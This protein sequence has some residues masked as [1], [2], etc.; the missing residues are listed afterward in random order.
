MAIEVEMF[1]PQFQALLQSQ[2]CAVQQSHD[3][4]NGAVQLS[5][6]QGDFCRAEDHRNTMGHLAAGHW[7]DRP[8]INPQ[9]VLVKE[10]ESAESLVLRGGADLLA[11]RQPGQEGRDFGGSEGARMPLL[12][13]D[14]ESAI[15]SHQL[16]WCTVRSVPGGARVSGSAGRQP[17][18]RGPQGKPA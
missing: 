6:D 14:D 4:C 11:G 3:E 16:A 8:D 13:K 12:V 18:R 17:G 7:L 9:D 15:H 10:E 2:S 5:E 1:H